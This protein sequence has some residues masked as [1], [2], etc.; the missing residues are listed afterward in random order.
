MSLSGRTVLVTGASRGIGRSIVQHLGD[1]GANV[2]AHYNA[3]HE[4]ALESVSDIPVGR[5]LLLQADLGL[6]G[7]ATRLW[8]SAVEWRGR[9]DAVVC[10]A[11]VL[12][13]VSMDDDDAT[14][15]RVWNESLQVNTLSQAELVRASTRHYLA[16]GGGVIVG[17]TSWVTQRGAGDACLGAYAASKA[18]TAALLK[19]VAR[20]YAKDGILTY[21]IAPGP[22]DTDMT[23]SAAQD[24][25]GT[26]AVRASLVM[27]ELVPP[28]E[29]AALVTLLCSGSLRHLTG[30]TL[31]MNGASYVR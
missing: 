20:A 24:Q 4:G 30:A 11:G 3:A 15:A 12:S 31:D 5:R 26:D 22:V 17:L 8:Q 25:G 10:N 6:T 2:V 9:I 13:K 18:A 19:T 1:A 14:W 27:G 16:A 29:I 21:S 28:A 23:R 7:E